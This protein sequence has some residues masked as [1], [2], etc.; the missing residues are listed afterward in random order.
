MSLIPRTYTYESYKIRTQVDDFGNPWFV[1]ADI[2]SVL[3]IQNLSVSVSKLDEDEKNIL[4]LGCDSATFVNESGLF[5]L[6]NSSKKAE[7]KAFKRWVISSLITAVGLTS[8]KL[9]TSLPAQLQIA[10]KR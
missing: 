10:A 6:I 4:S 7:A 8:A 3:N 2:C 9:K 1:A 5:S